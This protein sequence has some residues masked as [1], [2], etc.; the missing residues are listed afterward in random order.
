MPN[1][2]SEIHIDIFVLG[3]GERLNHDKTGSSEKPI[4]TCYFGHVTGYQPI[5]EQYF[6]IPNQPIRTRYLSHVTGYQT[7]SLS[8]VSRRSQCVPVP[9]CLSPN[10][11]QSQ[12]VPVPLC[13]SPNVSQ[14]HCVLEIPM[15]VC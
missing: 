3:F 7:K 15:E 12:C 14:S 10:M 11:P 9:M 13:P 2:L 8:L 4:R 1:L 5:R 6:L